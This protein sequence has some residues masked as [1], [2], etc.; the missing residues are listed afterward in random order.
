M[1]EVCPA[2]NSAR[3]NTKPAPVVEQRNHEDVYVQ[4]IWKLT[5]A[6]TRR[7]EFVRLK[8][9]GRAG[10]CAVGSFVKLGGCKDKNPLV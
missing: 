4:R 10:V 5:L 7:Y 6:D 3:A 2:H 9:A 8:Q 1:L